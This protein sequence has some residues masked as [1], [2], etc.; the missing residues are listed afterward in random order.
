MHDLSL[1]I[2]S[3]LTLAG[4]LACMISAYRFGLH[5]HWQGTWL[6]WSQP[7]TDLVLPDT[8]RELGLH[9]LSLQTWPLLTLA[10][11]LACKISAYKLGRY[12]HPLLHSI[13]V[14]L[15]T[16]SLAGNLA[17][18]ISAYKLGLYWHPL[19]H[20]I[21]DK[22]WGRTHIYTV[23]IRYFWQGNHQIYGHIRCIYTVLANP[24]DEAWG[25]TQ[26]FAHGTNQLHRHPRLTN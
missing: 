14:A 12:W 24:M 8:G 19:L 21:V 22:A 25:R 3:L 6:A 10:G 11:N 23:Y 17:C 16:G 1:Q 5:W 4:N 26:A 20:S 9:D 15:W 2:W 13:A 18:M 7:N